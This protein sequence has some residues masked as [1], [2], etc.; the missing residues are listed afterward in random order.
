MAY[1]R[2]RLFLGKEPVGIIKQSDSPYFNYHQRIRTGT[3]LVKSIKDTVK[4]VYY[5]SQVR[6]TIWWRTVC[7]KIR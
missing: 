4:V 1:M 7:R 3:G 5:K 2:Y 6:M